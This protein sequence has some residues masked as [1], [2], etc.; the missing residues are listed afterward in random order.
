M[1]KITELSNVWLLVFSM[2]GNH[3]RMKR[4]FSFISQGVS[5]C[6]YWRLR[7]SV[8]LQMVMGWEGAGCSLQGFKAWE[9]GFCRRWRLVPPSNRWDA[10][11]LARHWESRSKPPWW[12]RGKTNGVKFISFPIFWTPQAPDFVESQGQE[13]PSTLRPYDRHDISFPKQRKLC[14][15]Q[16]DFLDIYINLPCLYVH[17]YIYRQLIHNYPEH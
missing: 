1:K 17:T 3:Y 15:E 9:N 11:G 5:V 2:E 8:A 10:P 4:H 7:P 12:T 6:M 16:V 14:L 13:K